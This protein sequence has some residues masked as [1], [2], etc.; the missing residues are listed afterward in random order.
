MSKEIKLRDGSKVLDR[1][2]DALISFDERS[3]KFPI[4]AT[5]SQ[6]KPRSYSW[7]CA[8]CLDQGN[9]GACVGFGITHELIARPAPVQG[10]DDKFAREKIY[11]P[12]QKIDD[13]F[14]GAYPGA[15][16]FYE[17]TDMKSGLKIVTGLGY[18]DEYRWAFSFD[19]FL[20]GVGYNG[21]AIV[22]TNWYEGMEKIDEN[23]FI[24]PTGRVRGRHCYVFLSVDIK[25]KRA[26][27]HNSWGLRFGINGEAYVPFD[28]VEVLLKHQGE[29]AFLVGRHSRV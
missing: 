24:H 27:M 16:P 15:R 26:K 23:G 10:L 19:E 29:A 9:E 5:I 6:K 25:K 2:L 28:E 11:W 3:R 17:G 14:G 22:A 1:R 13:W 20:L 12:A 8:Q 21:P 7:S 18:C 4:R